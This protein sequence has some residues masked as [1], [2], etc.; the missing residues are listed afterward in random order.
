MRAFLPA[1]LALASALLFYLGSPRQQWLRAP[2]WPR[3]SRPAAALLTVCALFADGG[4]QPFATSL[5]IVL[6]ALMT[7][8]VACPLVGVLLGRW[9][10]AGPRDQTRD[11]ARDQPRDATPA[12][13]TNEA[14]R[15]APR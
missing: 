5:S 6:T 14:P 12:D 9:R 7:G 4:T 3:H 15:G 13:L 10:I 1:A 8:F 2:L 11:R